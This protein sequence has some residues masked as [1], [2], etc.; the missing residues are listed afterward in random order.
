MSTLNYERCVA[1]IRGYLKAHPEEYAEVIKVIDEA[2]LP[3]DIKKKYGN[4]SIGILHFIPPI[5]IISEN[6]FGFWV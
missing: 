3:E 6:V 4:N 2:V 1:I 5:R